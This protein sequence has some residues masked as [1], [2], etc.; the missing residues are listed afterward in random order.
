MRGN[1]RHGVGKSVKKYWLWQHGCT[2]NLLVDAL[3]GVPITVSSNEHD[4]HVAYL[5]KPPGG[6]DPFATSFKTHI[7]QDNIRLIFHCT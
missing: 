6:L 7:H 2:R 4:R 1:L 3:K 5:S